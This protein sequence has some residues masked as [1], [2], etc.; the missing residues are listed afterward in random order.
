[1]ARVDWCE[2][3]VKELAV[4]SARLAKEAEQ[5]KTEAEEVSKVL[6]SMGEPLEVEAKDDSNDPV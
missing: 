4:K 1:M 5:K 3:S 6:E 2:R